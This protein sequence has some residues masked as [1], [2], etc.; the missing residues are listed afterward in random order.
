[1]KLGV[2][3]AVRMFL[4]AFV[5]CVISQLPVSRHGTNF[6]QIWIPG[7][8]MLLLKSG[9]LLYVLCICMFTSFIHQDFEHLSP[10]HSGCWGCIG[11]PNRQGPCRGG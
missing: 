6:S 10:R 11:E 3:L 2:D 5:C 8:V 7:M 9:L 4:K 1:M